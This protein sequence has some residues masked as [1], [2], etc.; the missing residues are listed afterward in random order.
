MDIKG[1]VKQ[2]VK[3]EKEESPDV[4]KSEKE[5]DSEVKT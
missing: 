1:L 2:V 4:K 5:R 3:D